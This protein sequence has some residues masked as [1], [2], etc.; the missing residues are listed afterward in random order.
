MPKSTQ[1]YGIKY[2][3]ICDFHLTHS[4]VDLDGDRDHG[5]STSTYFMTLGTKIVPW[6]WPNLVDSTSEVDATTQSTK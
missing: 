6:R 1:S 3:T 5:V 4:N 2:S